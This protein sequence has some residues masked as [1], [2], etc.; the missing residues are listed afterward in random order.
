MSAKAI[1]TYILMPFLIKPAFFNKSQAKEHG[2]LF[3]FTMKIFPFYKKKKKC[4]LN[5]L[6]ICIAGLYGINRG[7]I[8]HLQHYFSDTMSFQ[9]PLRKKL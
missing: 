1:Y 9:F 4:P 7:P 2:F 5:S 6:K 8:H 3:N